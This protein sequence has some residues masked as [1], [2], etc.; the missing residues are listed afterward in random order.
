M[1]PVSPDSHHEIAALSLNQTVNISVTRSYVKRSTYEDMT[2]IGGNKLTKMPCSSIM[3][4]NCHS[5]QPFAMAPFDTMNYT[6][7]SVSLI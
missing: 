5:C 2:R 3:S 7:N 4:S 1:W 6:Y